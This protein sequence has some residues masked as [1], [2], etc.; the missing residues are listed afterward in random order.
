MKQQPDNDLSL[1]N[2]SRRNFLIATSATIGA[3]VL[4]TTKAANAGPISPA[5]PASK[6]IPKIKAAFV[7][8]E[9]EYGMLW[10]GAIYDGEAALK[11]YTEQIQR[12]AK[13]LAIEIDMQTKPIYSLEEAERWVEQAKAHKP[14]GL[15]VVLLDRQQ[16]SWPSAYAAV[17]SGIP[18]VVFAPIG[19]AFTTNTWKVA[20]ENKCFI[21]S[22]DDF[23]QAASGLKMLAVNAKLREMRFVVIKGNERKDEELLHFGTKLR[24]V[25]ASSFLEEYNQI[26]VTDEIRQIAAEYMANA[27][28]IAGPTEQDVINGVKSF[29]VARNIL[30]REEADGI[31]M[32]CL[33]ALGKSKVSLPC[34]SWSLMLDHGI[35]AACEADLGACITHALVQNL[36]DR[37][38]FQQDPVPETA[39]E[40]LIG[41]HC[42]CPTRLNGLARPPEPYHLSYHHGKRDAVPV[43]K[44]KIGQRM[45]SADVL[46]SYDPEKPPQMIIS[47]GM[48]YENISVPPAG[49]CV[50]SVMVKLDNVTDYLGYPGFHQIFFYGDFKKELRNYCKLFGIEPVVV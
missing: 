38:G 33:G 28:R 17:E 29:A 5:G 45:T 35:P 46:L 3:S 18:A 14:D 39:K 41:A 6:Y 44:W 7:R 26:P 32:D 10:P 21:C 19:A 36:F 15:F 23:S 4:S 49:G 12:A 11:N 9:G 2:P 47:S 40:C 30:E 1:T 22:T 31:T 13:D 27:T 16:H 48:V 43:P 20:E 8:R 34:I 24:Y 42:T 25:P 50:V 37:P